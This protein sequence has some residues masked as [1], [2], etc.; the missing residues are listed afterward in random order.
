MRNAVIVD[1]FQLIY[2]VVHGSQAFGL[3]GPESDLDLKGIIA[4]PPSWY[5]GFLPSPEQLI[6]NKDHTLYDVRKFFK[7]AIEANPT[8]IEMLWVPDSSI[9]T[10]TQ[11]AE[12]ILT[13][14]ERFLSLRVADSFGK[15]ALSQ[16]R[17][18]KTHRRWLLDPPKVQPQRKDFQLSGKPVISNDQIGAADSLLESG[19]ISQDEIPPNFM[20]M[21]DR[22]RSYRAAVKEWQQFQTWLRERNPARAKLEKEFGYDTKHAL[23]LVRLL[24]MAFEILTTGKVVVKRP[25]REELLAI[26]RGSWKFD[27][28]IEYAEAMHMKIV[29]AKKSCRLPELPDSEYLNMLCTEIIMDC[30]K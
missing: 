5:S 12:R 30:L 26:K 24:R 22:E 29:E 2:E 10:C 3:D 18:I 11:P 15:Y 25:D 7:L 1:T 6:I 4:G 13:E 9:R 19:R 16:L 14:R 27:Q 20:L 17:R 23:H 8:A 21:L 28:L